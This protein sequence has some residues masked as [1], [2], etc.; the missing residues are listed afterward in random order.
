MNPLSYF[1]FKKFLFAV[2]AVTYHGEDLG[3]HID[4]RVSEQ[5]GVV[6]PEPFV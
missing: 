3:H 5:G 6:D 1:K 2:K 4:E